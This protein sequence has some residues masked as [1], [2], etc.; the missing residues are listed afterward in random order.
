MTNWK[1]MQVPGIA[2]GKGA[3]KTHS[4]PGEV[5]TRYLAMGSWHADASK[6]GTRRIKHSGGGK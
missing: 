2:A 1:A 4:R 6:G 5:R 3:A